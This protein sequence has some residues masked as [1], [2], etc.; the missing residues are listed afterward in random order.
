MSNLNLVFEARRNAQEELRKLYDEHGVENLS[1]EV[2][3]IEGRLGASIKELQEREAALIAQA[4][5]DKAADEARARNEAGDIKPASKAPA[6]SIEHRLNAL[7]RGELRSV[8]IGWEARD[9]VDLQ[10]A[11]TDGAELVESSLLGEIHDLMVENSPIMQLARIIRTA[12]GADLIVPKV[13]SHSAAALVAEAAAFTDDAPQFTTAT[14]GSYKFGFT[15]QISRELEQ[16]S[17]FNVA[18]FVVEQGSAA[19]G[20]GV[21]A[22]FVTGSGS[23]Q[24]NGVDNAT[25]GM[26]TAAIAAVTMDELIEAQHSVLSVQRARASWLFNDSTIEAI[27]KLK[28]SSGNY[29]W[30]PGGQAGAPDVLLG[31]PIYSDPNVAAL[32]TGNDFGVFGDMMGFYIRMAGGVQVDRS[33]HVGFV[34]DLVTYRFLVRADSEI[35]D[36]TGIRVLTNA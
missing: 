34:N 2:R 6:D 19:L 10:K 12:G 24:P 23:S 16:D 13:T 31:N 33:E 11:S 27:R 4:D 21:D 25:T 29:I 1:A 3:E 18:S 8:E 14:L 28:D 35:I 22:Y 17:G 15:V 7:K 20:R 5:R 36:T 30:R 9:N 26:T 32:G